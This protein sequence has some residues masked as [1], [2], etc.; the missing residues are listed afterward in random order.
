MEEYRQLCLMSFSLNRSGEVIQKQDLLLPQQVT[1]DPNPSKLEEMVN[2]A[3]NH[4]LI[5]HSNVKSN[6]IYNVVIRTFKEGQAP[7]LY[8]GLAYHQ[9]GL[10]SV[11]AP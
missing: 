11:V 3:I 9:P 8:A 1:F 6:T 7:Q 10:S 5:N 4:A 2:S